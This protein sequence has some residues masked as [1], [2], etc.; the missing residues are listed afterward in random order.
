M[1]QSSEDAQAHLET[2]QSLLGPG[3]RE[4]ESF[5]DLTD[6]DEYTTDE[7]ELYA[8][9]DF[10]QAIDRQQMQSESTY[11]LIGL[12]TPLPFIKL[13]NQV[14]QGEMSPLIGDEVILG[15][16]RDPAN[17]TKPSHVPLHT[18]SRHLLFRPI[19]LKSQAEAEI[20]PP[21]ATSDAATPGGPIPEEATFA[22][23]K[24]R[25]RPK[26]ATSRPRIVVRSE[27]DVRNMDIGS[28]PD[29]IIIDIEPLAVHGEPLAPS[30]RLTKLQAERIVLG[31]T[32]RNR[33]KRSHDTPG[34]SNP[35]LVSQAGRRARERA[36]AAAGVGGSG[37]DGEEADME[38]NAEAGPSEDVIV[39]RTRDGAP[40]APSKAKGQGYGGDRPCSGR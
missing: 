15:M 35:V 34:P 9:L 8:V 26:G 6:E 18:A 16:V 33:I 21:P 37:H 39:S 38:G 32:A 4:V 31:L 23:P 14:Y 30:T 3:W 25:G 28:L 29:N 5:E 17:P 19:V 2:G 22:L 12:D 36:A 11:Q 24:P 7:E 13:G 20:N 27:E 40:R 10:G 1:L